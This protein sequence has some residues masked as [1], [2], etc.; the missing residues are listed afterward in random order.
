VTLDEIF[1]AVEIAV[2]GDHIS[3]MKEETKILREKNDAVLV[4]SET[5]LSTNKAAQ[6]LDFSP[7]YPPWRVYEKNLRGADQ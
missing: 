5:C 4:D 6:R 1:R 7:R 2:G 3:A